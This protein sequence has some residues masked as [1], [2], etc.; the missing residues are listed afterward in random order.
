[1]IIYNIRYNYFFAKEI[2]QIEWLNVSGKAACQISWMAPFYSMGK[3]YS[4]P[5]N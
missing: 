1:M 3:I 5:V 4:Y 2:M